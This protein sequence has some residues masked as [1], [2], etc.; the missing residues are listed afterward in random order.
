MAGIQLTGISTGIDTNAIVQQLMTVES[1]QLVKYQTQ[2]GDDQKVQTTLDTCQQNL[3]SLQTAVNAL[4]DSSTLAAY[5][6]TSSDT[7]ILTLDASDKANESSHTVQ[8]NQVATPERWVHSAG[9][10]YAEDYVGAGTFI[11]SYDHK[12]TTL[13]TTADTTLNDLVGMINNDAN[14]PGVTA[15]LLYHDGA[16]HLVLSGNDA[17]SDY[18]VSINPSNTEVWS[19]GSALTTGS[20]NATDSTLLTRLDQF[21]GVLAG[22]ESIT[23]TGT[24]HDG[25]SVNQTFTVTKDT[26]INHLLGTIGDAFGGTATATLVNGQIVLADNTSGTSHMT[27]QLTY[28]HG[29]GST[30]TLPALS[31][32]TKGGTVPASLSGFAGG[33]FIKTQSAQDSQIKVDGYPPGDNQWIT[34]SSNTVDDVIQGVTLH[35]HDT[36]T[37]QTSLTRD[38]NSL[39]TKLSS[40]VS[41]YNTATSFIQDNS[42]YNVETKVA[43]VLMTDSTVR[44]ISDSLHNALLQQARGFVSSVDKFLSPGQ[45]GLE[46]DSN[47]Q[48]SLNTSE[49]EDAV[50]KDYPGVLD[51][52]GATQKGSSD[53]SKI[54]FYGSSSKYTVGGTYNVQVTVSGGAITSAKIKSNTESRYRD[55]TVNGN[56]VTGNAAFDSNG[57]PVNPENGLQLTVDLSQDGTYTATVQVK[58]GF[59]GTMQD[60]L[61]KFL[62]TS[63]GWLTLDQESTQQQIS[64][65]NDRIS[66]EQDRLTNV[67]TR[68]KTKYAKLEATL[69]LLKAQMAELGQSG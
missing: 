27:L 9:M 43:G 20:N 65:L 32:T 6:T 22:G 29:A 16:Y 30:L 15:S 23:I 69:T 63:G 64:N 10:E 55:A 50:T 57:N 56:T 5:T 47:G 37:V 51:L 14:N 17:G 39:E 48:L 34:R 24:R 33:N 21:G 58:Q 12:E 42:G 61:D 35:L 31:E 52:I 18:Q 7:D 2:L 68:L 59:A 45:I 36:G 67:E 49:F 26:T 41:A 40:L 44:S 60:M 1:Q 8:V 53:N 11:Y 28:N 4:S 25:T 54:A 38:V 66:K 3:K 19:S 46:F 62:K 13:T